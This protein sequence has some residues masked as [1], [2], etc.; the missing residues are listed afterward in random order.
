MAGGSQWRAAAWRAAALALALAAAAAA[1]CASTS[2]EG[3][4]GTQPAAVARGEALARQYCGAC[5]GLGPDGQS[6]YAGAPSFRALRFDYNAISRQ[7]ETSHWHEG[8]AGMPPES[9]SLEDVGYIGA[10]VRSLRR[11]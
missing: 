2:F 10:Y 9:M 6:A 5:H 1:G 8:Y 4:Y 11:R 3:P 7:R